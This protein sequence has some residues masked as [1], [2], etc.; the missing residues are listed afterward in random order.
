LRTQKA[1]LCGEV[2]GLEAYV[3]RFVNEEDFRQH[4]VR[5]RLGYAST[6]ELVYIFEE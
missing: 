1:L 5:E 2:A 4:V 3:Q 6:N